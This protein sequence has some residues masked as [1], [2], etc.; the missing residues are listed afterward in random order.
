MQKKQYIQ[1][2]YVFLE[3]KFDVAITEKCNRSQK[4]HD[5]AK[6]IGFDQMEPNFCSG[7]FDQKR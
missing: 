1:I 5:T 6:F 4:V 7:N 3:N 2:K